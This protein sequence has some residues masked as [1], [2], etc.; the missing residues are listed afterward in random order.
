M[1]DEKGEKYKNGETRVEAATMS[2]VKN[3][4]CPTNLGCQGT[5][6]KCDNCGG[7]IAYC[8]CTASETNECVCGDQVLRFTRPAP[9]PTIKLTPKTSGHVGVEKMTPKQ[10]EAYEELLSTGTYKQ[11]IAV[12]AE[13]L[14][15][16]PARSGRCDK[17]GKDECIMPP[18]FVVSCT[19]REL[20]RKTHDEVA[21]ERVKKTLCGNCTY[22]LLFDAADSISVIE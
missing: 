20:S 15:G 13:A 9:V 14:I 10:K 21:M 19:T 16:S 7:E 3:F 8:Q 12:S 5:L 11:L 22:D 6:Y 18:Q 17:Y 4:N 1:S 2:F